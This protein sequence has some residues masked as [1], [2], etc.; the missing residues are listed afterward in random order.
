MSVWPL[1]ITAQSLLVLILSVVVACFP[2]ARFPPSL[3]NP[4]LADTPSIL[5]A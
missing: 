1:P 5:E 2:R 3:D 4:V